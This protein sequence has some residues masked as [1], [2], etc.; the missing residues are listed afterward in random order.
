MLVSIMTKIIPRNRTPVLLAPSLFCGLFGYPQKPAQPKRRTS[1]GRSNEE[2]PCKIY[3]KGGADRIQCAA[4]VGAGQGAGLGL[5]QGGGKGAG[6]GAVWCAQGA[7]PVCLVLLSGC[8]FGSCCGCC[9]NNSQGWK[10]V[11]ACAVCLCTGEVLQT[12]SPH[13]RVK[14]WLRVSVSAFHHPPLLFVWLPG[15]LICRFVAGRPV[16]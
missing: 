11:C 7:V 13:A 9:S 5:G 8:C 16:G 6:E 14:R 2:L 3:Q 4:F 10:D 12:N 1:Q 15:V